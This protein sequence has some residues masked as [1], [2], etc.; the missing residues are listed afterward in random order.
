MKRRPQLVMLSVVSSTWNHRIEYI[1]RSKNSAVN[2]VLDTSWSISKAASLMKKYEFRCAEQ[3]QQLTKVLKQNRI[4]IGELTDML[5][6]NDLEGENVTPPDIIA[7]LTEKM[8]AEATI[9]HVQVIEVDLKSDISEWPKKE[10]HNLT[11]V[12]GFSLKHLRIV[13][14]FLSSLE[15]YQIMA[16]LLSLKSLY[17]DSDSCIEEDMTDYTIRVP[18]L[19]SLKKLTTS[20]RCNAV[21]GILQLAPNL[22]HFE[23]LITDGVDDTFIQHLVKYCPKIKTL[24]IKTT[25][26]FSIQVTDQGI[27]Y[28]LQNFPN[29]THLDLHCCS[30]VSGELFTK[31]GDCGKNLKRLMVDK[32]MVEV[33][34]VSDIYFSGDELPSL[35][36]LIVLGFSNCSDKFVSSLIAI[37]PNLKVLSTNCVTI[38]DR[39]I[40]SATSIRSLKY[41][42]RTSIN[43][44]ILQY[45]YLEKLDTVFTCVTHDVLEKASLPNL[46]YLKLSEKPPAPFDDWLRLLLKAC[47]NLRYLTFYIGDRTGKLTISRKEMR[48][49]LTL[50]LQILSNK[51]NW[52]DL[53]FLDIVPLVDGELWKDRAVKLR[54]RLTLKFKEEF[55]TIKPVSPRL[56]QRMVGI[57]PIFKQQNCLLVFIKVQINTLLFA[58]YQCLL[59]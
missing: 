13:T 31:I 15:L 22:E 42:T 49:F 26:S 55:E 17:I 28:A 51:Q 12:N 35:E 4:N 54:P 3:L 52:P 41:S 46:K 59:C 14:E 34:E 24:I 37:A 33:A 38:D 2:T 6:A 58:V 56:Y 21:V 39:L 27:L 44:V 19:H 36:E 8:K 23:Y 48:L 43:P 9:D 1:V 47:P 5:Y 16:N 53:E 50:M 18:M 30:R 10:L 25:E 7:F 32:N 11:M 29:M 57:L 45:R 20:L 40:T